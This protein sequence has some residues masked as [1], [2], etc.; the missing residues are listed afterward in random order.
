M[1]TVTQRLLKGLTILPYSDEL[2]QRVR[3]NATKELNGDGGCDL[4]S[5]GESC[6]GS[7]LCAQNFLPTMKLQDLAPQPFAF[8]AV[9][10]LSDTGFRGM[11]HRPYEFV[12]CISAAPPSASN[13]QT[14]PQMT[15]D[16]I[17][18]YNFCVASAYRRFG[19][20]TKLLQAVYDSCPKRQRFLSVKK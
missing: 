19:I 2:A 6:F 20:G 10:D 17:I 4:R 14:F 16:S 3:N 5:I 9:T 13:L 18:I 1:M 11:T 8:I 12:G 15:R 7:E